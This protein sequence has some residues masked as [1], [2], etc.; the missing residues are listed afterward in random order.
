MIKLA[1]HD[2]VTAPALPGRQTM[3]TQEERAAAYVRLRA[4]VSSIQQQA[5]Q[6]GIGGIT[7]DDIQAEIEA[8]R[9][10]RRR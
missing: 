6:R 7:D 4:A 1:I 5:E 9:A 2:E 3:L 10:A 8:S